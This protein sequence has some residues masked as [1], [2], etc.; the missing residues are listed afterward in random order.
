M[1]KAC[2]FGGCKRLCQRVVSKIFEAPFDVVDE[3]RADVFSNAMAN[4]NSL[5][6]EVLAIGRQRVGRNLPATAAKT[7][8][9]IVKSV[10]ACIEAIL[11]LPRKRRNAGLRITAVN[12]LEWG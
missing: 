7:V 9:Q 10:A 5:N 3:Q 6:H 11:H 8:R 2:S 12:D 1:M 4:E